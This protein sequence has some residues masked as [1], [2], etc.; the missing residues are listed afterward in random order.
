MQDKPWRDEELRQCEEALPR[1]KEG[2]LEKT[3][4]LYKAKTGVR[5]DGF[6]PKVL[7]DLTKERR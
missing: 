1:L 7:V 5:C 3:S 6:H 2:V 4:G